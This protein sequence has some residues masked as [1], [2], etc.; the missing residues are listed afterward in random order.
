MEKTKKISRYILAFL[1]PLCLI[2]FAYYLNGIYWGSTKSILASDAFTQ[3]ANFYAS[4]HD[5]LH[6][7]ESWLYTWNAA[8]GLNYLGLYSYYLGGPVTFLVYFFDKYDIPNAVYLITLVKFGL[9]GLTSYWYSKRSFTIAEWKHYLLSA[10]YAL[11]SFGVAY[12]E[13]PMWL[14]A[15]YILP[16][17]IGGIDTLL[18]KKKYV[19]L[20]LAYSLLFLTNFYMAYIVGIFSLLYFIAQSYSLSKMNWHNFGRYF[21]TIIC[22]IMTSGIIIVPTVFNMFRTHE[23]LSKVTGLLTDNSGLWDL[24]IKNM[25]GVYD[26]TKFGTV[27]FI[28][29]GLFPLLLAIAFFLHSKIKRRSKLVFGTLLV[30][31]GGSFYLQPLDLF[32]Q[33][34]HSPSMFLYRYSLVWSFLIFWLAGKSWEA[35]L[36]RDKF[37]KLGLFYI[38]LTSAA[39]LGSFGHYRYAGNTNFILTLFLVTAYILIV[40]VRPSL[41]NMQR[42]FI[43]FLL[44]MAEIGFNSY[45]L[46][47]GTGIEWHYPATSLYNGTMTDINNIVGKYKGNAKWLRMAS[48]DPISRDDSLNYGYSSV[49]LFSSMRNRP[50]QEQM[51]LLGF[52]SGGNNLNISYGNNT[53]LMDSLLGIRLNIAKGAISKYGFVEQQPSGTY[54]VYKNKYQVGLGVVSPN[55]LTNIKFQQTDNLGNQTKLM[56]MV[57]GSVSSTKYFSSVTPKIVDVQNTKATTDQSHFYLNAQ[58][59]N[60]LQTIT[61]EVDVPAHAQAYLSMFLMQSKSGNS[62]ISLEVPN[63]NIVSNSNLSMVGQYLDLGKYQSG[64]RIRF[65][66]KIFGSSSMAF[67]KPNVILLD[68]KKYAAAAERLSRNS[69]SLA[70]SSSKITGE[71]KARQAKSWLYTSIPYDSGWRAK[72]NGRSVKTR[73]INNTFL[74]LPLAK[75][76]NKISLQFWPEGLGLGA[77]MSLSGIAVFC[78]ITFFECKSRKK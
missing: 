77:L 47:H 45:A 14:D 7:K 71:A 62:T 10:C 1:L 57:S 64:E 39:Y 59:E 16:I 12:A 70:I 74:T 68:T 37:T 26:T 61:W 6:G 40:A 29:V 75:G 58:N 24:V 55:N 73:S 21:A 46:I 8:L 11:M 25:A 49:D 13:Q 35:G 67:A 20:F 52:K 65:T 48:L 19:L 2:M 60:S 43:L 9:C 72:V 22:S 27:P 15:I 4:F 18:A 66:T 76:K 38:V 28:Y 63:K 36:E 32:W 69:A 42:K 23:P 3:T 50:F 17:V 31:V 30:I 41:F 51:N 54:R 53:L 33:G 34:G 5:V 44:V 78:T 56:N